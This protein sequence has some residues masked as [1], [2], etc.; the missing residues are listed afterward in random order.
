MAFSIQAESNQNKDLPLDLDYMTD[1]F[2]I[3]TKEVSFPSPSFWTIEKHLFYLLRNSTKKIFESKY[4]M[5]PDY[6]SFDEYGTVILAPLLMY[7]NGVFSI[8]DF[9][10]NEVIVPEFSFVIEICS[11]KFRAKDLLP[12]DLE[13]INW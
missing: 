3:T 11:D 6:L 9:D 5:R 7:I 10:L 4:S 8:E 12:S 1:R 2:T 13:I